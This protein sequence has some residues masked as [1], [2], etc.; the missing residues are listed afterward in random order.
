VKERTQRF[1][2]SITTK[3][4]SGYFRCN[5][6][7]QQALM[8]HWPIRTNENDAAQPPC[9]AQNPDREGGDPARTTPRFWVIFDGA[10]TRQSH[11]TEPRL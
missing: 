9:T 2:N 4:N 7:R 1:R 6:A 11:Q 5:R 8:G 10:D 3:R